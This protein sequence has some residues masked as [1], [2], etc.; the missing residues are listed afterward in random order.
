MRIA[1]ASQEFINRD[2][3][4]NVSQLLSSMKQA[5]AN[6]ADLVCFGEAFLQGFDALIWDVAVDIHMAIAQDDALMKQI[7]QYTSDVGIDLCFGYLEREANVLYSSFA[8]IE[9]GELT[10]NYRRI[11]PGWKEY[12]RTDEHY[13]EGSTTTVFEYRGKKCAVALCGDLWDFP[14]RFKL[15]QDI[16]LWPIYVDYSITEWET[17]HMQEYAAQAG[18]IDSD[19][20]LI[21]SVC[22]PTSFGGSI[23]FRD[24]LIVDALLP[25]EVG[26]LYIDFE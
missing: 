17:R 8:M 23:H 11:S 7:K 16:L 18:K 9:Q 21:N 22:R 12:Y 13:Q 4:Y 25:G 14:E 20:L 3:A 10:Y 19:V 24:N 5:K 15:N 26:I 1:L 2:V 6:G